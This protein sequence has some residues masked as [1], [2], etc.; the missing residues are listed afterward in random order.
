MKAAGKLSCVT[1]VTQRPS[2]SEVLGIEHGK[3][4]DAG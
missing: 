2:R 3:P 4:A 1:S